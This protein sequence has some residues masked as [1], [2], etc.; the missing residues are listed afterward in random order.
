MPYFPL[1]LKQEG[2]DEELGK[3]KVLSQDSGAQ[4]GGSTDVCASSAF[5]HWELK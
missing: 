1:A 2:L 3:W 4:E 5:G